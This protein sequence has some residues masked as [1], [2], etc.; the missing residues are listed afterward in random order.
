VTDRT[1]QDVG[2]VTSPVT[3]KSGA[4]R[5]AGRAASGVSY[6]SPQLRGARAYLYDADGHD[7][8]I[9]LTADVRRS[10]SERQLLWVDVLSRDREELTSLCR[11]LELPAGVDRLA[12]EEKG[13]PGLV[14]Y[15]GFMHVTLVAL[16]FPASDEWKPVRTSFLWDRQMILTAHPGEVDAFR[17]FE[18]QDRG[19]TRIGALSADVLLSALLDWHLSAYFRAIE[20]LERSIDR[21]DERVLTRA[22]HEDLVDDLVKMRRRVSRLR[23]LLVPQREVFHALTRP[24][25]SNEVGD[26]AA[27]HFASVGVRYERTREALEHGADLVHGSFALH[28]SRTAESVNAFLKVLTFGTFLLGAMSVVA[29]LLGMNFQ[30]HL[31]ESGER[32]FWAVVGFVLL[33]ASSAIA[34]AR[35]RHWI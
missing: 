16:H 9:A 13:P 17:G 19:E 20:L 2:P 18:A 24:D 35:H 7:R 4:R 5:N 6:S 21:F 11:A 1:L 34:V 14:K 15:D 27:R 29:G 28:A 32:G 30:A 31:F 8:E 12:F 25:V 10:L 22:R 23:R 33:A 3:E 26:D